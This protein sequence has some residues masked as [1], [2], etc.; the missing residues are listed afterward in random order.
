VK[1]RGITSTRCIAE[2]RTHDQPVAHHR[3][4]GAEADPCTAR[5][6]EGR[7]V[8]ASVQVE[9]LDLAPL[10]AS[11]APTN[12]D[13]PVTASAAP[14]RSPATGDGPAKVGVDPGA[15]VSAT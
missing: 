11:G 1:L 14:K 7:D 2:W 8:S 9:L 15:P 13:V 10:P 3:E 6:E 5:V 4:C 12:S